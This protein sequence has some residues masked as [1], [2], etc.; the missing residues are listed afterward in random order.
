MR[1]LIKKI[2]NPKTILFFIVGIL[3][4]VQFNITRWNRSQIFEWDVKVYYAYLPAAF[5]YGDLHMKYFDTIPEIADYAWYSLDPNGNRY[6][7]GSM[8]VAIMYMPSFFAVHIWQWLTGGDMSGYS[9][10]YQM[11]ISLNALLF[12]YLGL[13]ALYKLLCMFYK[14]S[15]SIITL[16]LTVFATN[17]LY[18]ATNE[19][20]LTHIY[21]FTLCSFFILYVVKWFHKPTLLTAFVI[22]LL[23]GVISLIR[24]PNLIIAVII[25]LYGAT[26]LEKLKQN[27]SLIFG[28]YFHCILVAVAFVLIWLPQLLYWKVVTGQYFFYT[29]GEESFNFANP[30]IFNLLFSYRKGWFVYTPLSLAAIAGI[31]IL[32]ERT[33]GFRMAIIVFLI[34]Q[35][36]IASSWWC[37]WYGGCFGQRVMIDILP[38]M[39]IP[40]A[41]FVSYILAHIN[42]RKILLSVVVAFI[43]I[44]NIIQS[45]QYRYTII[46]WDSMTKK[47]YWHVF[48]KLHKPKDMAQYLE[49]PA[50]IYDKVPEEPS[51]E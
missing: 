17:I 33:R 35:I 50:Y 11:A 24:L 41:A 47:A 40:L 38:L 44:L 27:M 21:S 46:H 37:W 42:W 16:I 36:Y 39:A 2:Y 10:P 12:L 43:L 6:L 29:Y 49:K 4:Y 51:S 1:G 8:G 25:P 23:L 7:K 5:I 20:G 31:F 30:Q 48:M 22:G 34:L 15:V 26:S 28:N 14:K 18:Y 19:P 32:K 3:L 45:F 13:L 9:K